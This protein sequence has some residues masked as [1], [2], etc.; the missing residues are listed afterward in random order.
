MFRLAGFAAEDLSTAR[1]K[2]LK[3]RGP[4]WKIRLP[5]ADKPLNWPEG[6]VE[7][8]STMCV[9]STTRF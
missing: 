7:D 5:P 4:R 1:G 2:P 3:G 9:P 8:S 6:A